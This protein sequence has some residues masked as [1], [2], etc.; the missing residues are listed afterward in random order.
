MNTTGMYDDIITMV[1]LFVGFLVGY[2]VRAM[3]GK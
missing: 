3:K 2:G 1:I